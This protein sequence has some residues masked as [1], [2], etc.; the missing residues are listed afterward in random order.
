MVPLLSDPA[1]A[2]P[3]ALAPAT[4]T[5]RVDTAATV[6]VRQEVALT[7][8]SARYRHTLLDTT[9]TGYVF[10]TEQLASQLQNTDPASLLLAEFNALNESLVFGT[11]RHGHLLGLLNGP[12]LAA[13]WQGL[14]RR[15]AAT[16]ARLPTLPALLAAMD[17]QVADPAALVEGLRHKGAYGILYAGVWGHPAGG[18]EWVTTRPVIKNYFG[19]L[20]LPLQLLATAAPD[21]AAPAEVCVTRTGTL[22]PL[23]WDED[24]F[25]RLMRRVADS[26]AL[27]VELR[28]T[29]H[30]TYRLDRLTG[31]LLGATQHLRAEVPGVYVNDV[32]HTLTLSA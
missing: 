21:P 17:Q 1:P 24:A 8:T 25:R 11:D 18:P 5:Y 26:F 28:L 27:R 30:E 31:W 4:R 12:D 13:R 6:Q 3:L 16:Y 9:A 10:H 7:E 32:R 19:A 20:D 23:A 2:L 14:R 22:D 15:L 29:C